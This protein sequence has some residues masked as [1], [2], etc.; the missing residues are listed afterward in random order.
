M[1]MVSFCD[2]LKSSLRL[3]NFD[4]YRFNRPGHFTGT[5]DAFVKIAR[6]EGGIIKFKNNFIF[7]F[8]AFSL[9]RSLAY[10]VTFLNNVFNLVFRIS[11]I[12]G[13]DLFLN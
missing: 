1:R 13:T 2:F 9:V 10:N 6:H 7:I 4:H 12:P 5:F 11:G 8:S 3:Q